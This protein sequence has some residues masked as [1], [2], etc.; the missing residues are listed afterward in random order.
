MS[1]AM[2]EAPTTLPFARMGETVSETSTSDP[3]LRRRVISRWST[4][5]PRATRERISGSVSGRSGAASM[6]TDLP[7]ASTQ[8]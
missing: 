1:R 7:M 3:S 2:A 6:V 4:R 8:E 5:S